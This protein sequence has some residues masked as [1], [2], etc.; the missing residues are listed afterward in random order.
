MKFEKYA[1]KM[2]QQDLDTLEKFLKSNRLWPDDEGAYAN[3]CQVISFHGP[4]PWTKDVLKNWT[5][6]Y[7][8]GN[9]REGLRWRNPDR[10]PNKRYGQH[11]GGNSHFMSRKEVNQLPALSGRIDHAEH[12]SKEIP[13]P[14]SSS[15]MEEYQWSRLANSLV[16]E[17]HSD[18]AAI[19]RAVK[20]AGGGEA[21]YQAGVAEQKR[22]RMER[23]RGR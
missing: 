2:T 13:R 21:G 20:A 14:V 18:T 17:R 6:P 4:R 22:I 15:K 8:L 1:A 5:L 16:G 12:P 7:I 3:A 11:S 23:E 9:S 10:D 19:Q